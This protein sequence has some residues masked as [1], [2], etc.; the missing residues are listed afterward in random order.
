MSEFHNAAVLNQ[1]DPGDLVEID[2]GIYYHWAVYI[3]T[4]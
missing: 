2:R 3:G 1:L 4:V